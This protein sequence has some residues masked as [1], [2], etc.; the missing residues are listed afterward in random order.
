VAFRESAER[1]ANR[2]AR[3]RRRRANAS[4]VTLGLACSQI[5]AVSEGGRSRIGIALTSGWGE[6]L[7]KG[8]DG[9]VDD[10]AGGHPHPG[11]ARGC[12]LARTYDLAPH[13]AGG[14]G[15]LRMPVGGNVGNGN[16]C[17]VFTLGYPCG[18]HDAVPM[19]S[20]EQ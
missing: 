1:P 14:V 19:A 5:S 16:V 4:T 17:L 11:A 8:L 20:A 2:A 10:L 12:V 13:A 7:E 6:M 3:R 15:R 9:G 18:Y